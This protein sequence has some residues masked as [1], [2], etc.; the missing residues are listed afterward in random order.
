MSKVAA[1]A[2]DWDDNSTDGVSYHN[3]NLRTHKSEFWNPRCSTGSRLHA[4]T[5]SDADTKN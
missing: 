4:K 3:E 1:A 5:I 2:A